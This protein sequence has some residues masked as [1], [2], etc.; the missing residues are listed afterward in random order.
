LKTLTL[1]GGSG[2]SSN[3]IE[4]N[5]GVFFGIDGRIAGHD[6]AAGADD[7]GPAAGCHATEQQMIDSV[8]G[9]SDFVALAERNAEK[10]GNFAVFVRKQREIQGM[11]LVEELQAFGAI[12]ADPDN[13]GTGFLELHEVVT[14]EA[15]LPCTSIGE[16]GGV[17]EEHNILFSDVLFGFP[18]CAVVFAGLEVGNLIA[19]EQFRAGRGRVCG[20]GTGLRE[21]G[22]DGK[23]KQCGNTEETHENTPRV[24]FG[25]FESRRSFNAGNRVGRE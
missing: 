13:F 10:T 12:T 18:D 17:K 11:V 14:E 16:G 21:E 23:N 22:S 8:D 3:G 2:E 1:L 20:D 6:F 5:C 4:H 19:F 24:E 25:E 7:K 15:G 9:T